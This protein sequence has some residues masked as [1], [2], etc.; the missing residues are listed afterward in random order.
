VN[1]DGDRFTV[2][3][4]SDIVPKVLA[5]VCVKM[6]IHQ[7]GA[8]PALKSYDYPAPKAPVHLKIT[9]KDLATHFANYNK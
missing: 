2:V 5:Q 8:Y 6:T 3:W 1:S 9:R 4:D 7:A